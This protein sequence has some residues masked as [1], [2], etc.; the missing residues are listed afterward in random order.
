MSPEPS[1][2]L[3]RFGTS[4]FSRMTDLAVQH[5]SMNFGQGVPDMPPEKNILE[6]AQRQLLEGPNQ[7]APS[8]GVPRL[9]EAIQATLERLYGLSYDSK[10]DITVT[11]GATQAIHSAISGLCE[12]GDRVVLIEPA[13]DSYAPSVVMAGA[14]VVSLA[15][16]PPEYRLT[17]EALTKAFST[18]PRVIVFNSPHN[19]TTRV[20]SRDEVALLASFCVK[21]DVIALS[22][23][24]YEHL[25]FDDCPHVPLATYPGMAERTLTISSVSKTFGVTGWRVG[26][27]CGPQKLTDALRRC[28][29]FVTF[30][31][32][33]PLQ[34]ATAIALEDAEHNGFYP[35]FRAEFGELRDL[36]AQAIDE[37]GL[38]ALPARG[39]YF[40]LA[41]YGHLSD[42]ADIEFCEQMTKKIGLTAIPMS[43]FYCGEVPDT[44]VIRFCFARFKD[45]IEQGR[46]TLSGLAD[47]AGSW[48]P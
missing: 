10:T 30:A 17:E 35:R 46:K 12:P 39:T 13:Y 24:V 27:A 15:L 4:I 38:R 29:Q 16:T 22:D 37:S 31:A 5:N 23:E 6:A 48:K 32:P 44:R 28:H 47:K 26:W 43:P 9:R 3:D 19:P 21:H 11:C 8:I 18:H 45:T 40:I 36:M 14:E 1:H 20:F 2:K 41:E 7:Y 34:L 33:T 25:T 42:L